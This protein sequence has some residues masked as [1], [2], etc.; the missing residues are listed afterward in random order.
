MPNSRAREALIAVI[1]EILEKK[2]LTQQ[3]FSELCHEHV[4]FI[5]K[6]VTG[7]RKVTVEEMAVIAK[8][9]GM[10]ELELFARY[11]AIRDQIRD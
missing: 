6:I 3:Q 5:P 4:S 2:Q 10:T 9:A 1:R 7:R 11:W 8:A